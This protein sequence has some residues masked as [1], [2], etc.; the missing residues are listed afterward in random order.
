[1]SFLWIRLYDIRYNFNLT[2]GIIYLF[3]VDLGSIP[4]SLRG[5]NTN[6]LLIKSMLIC[7]TAIFLVVWSLEFGTWNSRRKKELYFG[8]VYYFW[9]QKSKDISRS[10]LSNFKTCTFNHA[11]LKSMAALSDRQDE[12]HGGGGGVWGIC[13]RGYGI[14]TL[15]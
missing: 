14:L 11:L 1:M 3:L 2:S 5:W 7:T 6:L 9:L 12:G 13:V 15:Y 8:S 4:V 10:N